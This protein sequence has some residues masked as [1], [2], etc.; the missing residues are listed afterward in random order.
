MSGDVGG[1]WVLVQTGGVPFLLFLA[2]LG[3]FTGQV[4][5]SKQADKVLTLQQ[6]RYAENDKRWEERWREEKARGDLERARADRLEQLL[7]QQGAL[8]NRVGSLAERVVEKA[9]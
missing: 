7:F 6:D 8:A 1:L 2:V 9:A 3:L 4:S 5:S